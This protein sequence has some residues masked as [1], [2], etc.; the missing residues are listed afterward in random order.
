MEFSDIRQKIVTRFWWV[1]VIILLFNVL[2]WGWINSRKFTSIVSFDLSLNKNFYSISNLS[3]S[4]SDKTIINENNLSSS[5]SANT[6]AVVKYFQEFWTSSE[7]ISS[8][9]KNGALADLNLGEKPNYIVSV[10]GAEIFEIKNEFS[11]QDEAEKFN[12][13]VS[14]V[15]K[16]Q[17]QDWNQSKPEMLQIVDSEPILNVTSSDKSIQFKLLPTVAALIL[18][19]AAL[20]ITPI[21]QKK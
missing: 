13:S 8:I 6:T 10:Y 4:L 7:A 16:S 14:Q 20:I 17:L 15:Y 2:G 9:K 19:I 12:Q 11:S 3:K 5:F 21:R 18:G 1:L